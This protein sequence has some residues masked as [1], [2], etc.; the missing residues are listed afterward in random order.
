MKQSRVD[1]P[2]HFP[3]SR[4]LNEENTITY[5]VYIITA[6]QYTLVDRLALWQY[7]AVTLD[8]GGPVL[9]TWTTSIPKARTV[10]L[11][12]IPEE[13]VSETHASVIEKGRTVC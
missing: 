6:I 2:Q 3:L 12:K 10:E 5:L 4:A 7:H 8:S 1:V 11:R 13:S 9:K